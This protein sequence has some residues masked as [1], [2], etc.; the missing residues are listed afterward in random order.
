MKKT[1]LALIM[2]LILSIGTILSGCGSSDGGAT[3]PDT[4][5]SAPEVTSTNETYTIRIG[6]P[7]VG[8]HQQNATMEEFKK[9]I[10][11]ASK[12]QIVVELYPGSQLGT[13]VQMIQGVQDGSIQ[14]VLIPS[15][16]FASFAPAVAITDLPYL[17][18]SS[19]E[20]Y[21]ILNSEDS[22]L[23]EYMNSKGFLVGGWLRNVERSILSKTKIT[24]MDDLNNKKIWSLPSPTL[25]D[26]LKAY[27]A[28][29]TSLDPG[30]IAVALQNGT[31]DGVETDPIFMGTM[32]LQESAKYLNM[33]PA[34]AM[35]NAFVYSA[36]WMA[37]LPQ[38]IQDLI[39]AT[40]KAVITE[41]EY[42]YVEQLYKTNMDNLMAGG[43]EVVNP[44]EELLKELKSAAAPLHD[45]FKNTNADCAKIY[46]D[47]VGMINAK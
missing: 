35:S 31:V 5:S 21:E 30:D 28:A 15:S 12:G 33:I 44:S 16:Y 22:T 41:F 25:Q 40:T 2:A 27:G 19:D 14:A 9:R 24:T 8:K 23:N 13:S 4:S 18:E 46:D 36:D 7:T 17:F 6:T 10:E 47:V 29:P 34:S 32:K 45:K 38:D 11:E 3:A 39:M 43:V 20:L 26:E 1:A 42:D 37:G